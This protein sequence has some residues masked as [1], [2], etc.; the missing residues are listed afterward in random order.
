V[1]RILK[2][3]TVRVKIL[4]PL[5]KRILAI[6]LFPFEAEGYNR[7]QSLG[8]PYPKTVYTMGGGAKNAAWARIRQNIIGVQMQ[9]PQQTEAAYGTALLARRGL[10]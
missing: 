4:H 10:S 1:E 5:A 8:T 3:Y 9:K 7:L 6:Y 2:L